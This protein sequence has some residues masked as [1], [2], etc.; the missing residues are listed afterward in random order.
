MVQGSEIGIGSPLFIF[1]QSMH[2]LQYLR[3]WF[4]FVGILTIWKMFVYSLNCSTFGLW[5]PSDLESEYSNC[6]SKVKKKNIK[7]QGYPKNQGFQ[8]GLYSVPY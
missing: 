7:K 8:S 1:I 2:I 3:V 4:N 6:I 5:H